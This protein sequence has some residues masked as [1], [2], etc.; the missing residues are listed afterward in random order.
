M[1]IDEEEKKLMERANK[2]CLKDFVS[3]T[4]KAIY[5][6][7]NL[8]YQSVTRFKKTK[9]FVLFEQSVDLNEL[10]QKYT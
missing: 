1:I 4:S 8:N 6:I 3:L 9:E 10:L 2:V 5:S 7:L